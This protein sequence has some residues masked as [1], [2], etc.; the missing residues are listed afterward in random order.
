MLVNRSY[1]RG[2]AQV[3]RRTIEAARA[4]LGDAAR[5]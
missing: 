4:L 1:L 5:D 3:D 2:V